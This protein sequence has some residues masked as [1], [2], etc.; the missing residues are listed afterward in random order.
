METFIVVAV[1]V[2]AAL[3]LSLFV[4]MWDMSKDMEAMKNEIR[5]HRTPIKERVELGGGF[6]DV[7]SVIVKPTTVE[8]VKKS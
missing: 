5:L 2:L 3:C 7:N 8:Y 6:D 4:V 1:I